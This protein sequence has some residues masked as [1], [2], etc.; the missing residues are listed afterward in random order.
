MNEN[1]PVQY[2]EIVRAI[3]VR[4]REGRVKAGPEFRHEADQL[5]ELLR[6]GD[7]VGHQQ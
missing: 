1:Q 4:T 7:E 5:G 6:Q 2:G 3:L